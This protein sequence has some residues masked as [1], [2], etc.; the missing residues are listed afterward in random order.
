M[1]TWKRIPVE[2][3]VSP[4]VLARAETFALDTHCHEFDVRGKSLKW[5][6]PSKRLLWMASGIEYIEPEL[7]DWIDRIPT[8]SAYYDIGASNGI[9][10]LYA[11]A[12]KLKVIAL[13]PDPANYFL[14]SWNAY[15]NRG[16]DIDISAFNIAA[17]DEFSVGNLYIRTMELGAHEKIVGSPQAMSGEVFVPQNVHAIQLVHLDKWIAQFG[18][19]SPEYVKIDVDGHESRVLKGA[20]ESLRK[21]KEVFIE[22]DQA[23]LDELCGTLAEAGLSMSEKHQV[24]NYEGLWNCIFTR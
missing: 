11:A 19:P 23:K 22:I 2:T 12:Q 9:F 7:L 6:A 1:K 15:L 4:D 10:A 24:Q 5:L 14:L 3:L 20:M 21:C 16:K 13:E 17:S 18:L 8:S